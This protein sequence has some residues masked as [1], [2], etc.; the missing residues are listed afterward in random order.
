MSFKAVAS[1]Q[2]AAVHRPAHAHQRLKR[3]A[4]RASR[5]RRRIEIGYKAVASLQTAA[6][7]PPENSNPSIYQSGVP[8]ASRK[9]KV[10]RSTVTDRAI[11][12]GLPAKV[13]LEPTIETRSPLR[14]V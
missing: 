1:L 8:L 6:V 14:I 5:P 2:T 11:R 4:R 9:L 13:I 12:A 10:S 7:H 3:A